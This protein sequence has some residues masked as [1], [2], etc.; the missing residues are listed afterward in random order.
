[1]FDSMKEIGILQDNYRKLEKNRKLTKKNI[2]DLVIPFRDKYNLTDLEALQV[3]RNELTI[4]QIVELLESK[5]KK[6]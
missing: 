5:N 3:V 6:D 2:C 1:M 4:L